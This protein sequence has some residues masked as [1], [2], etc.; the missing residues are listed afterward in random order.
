MIAARLVT[1][2]QIG[3]IVCTEKGLLPTSNIKDQINVSA[4]PC[5]FVSIDGEKTC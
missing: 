3:I 2:I 4:F 1:L 5:Q